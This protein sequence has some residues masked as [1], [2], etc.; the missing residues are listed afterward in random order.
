MTAYMLVCVLVLGA[1][2][3][4]QDITHRAER[5]DLYNRIMSRNLT[6][7]KGESRPP[8]SKHKRIMENWNGEQ[9]GE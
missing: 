4:A 9:G 2:I 5:R 6:E 1:V 8:Y 7:F 3:V